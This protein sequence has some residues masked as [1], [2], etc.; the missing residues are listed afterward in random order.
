MAE[1]TCRTPLVDVV[2]T[3]RIAGPTPG[4]HASPRKI[5]GRLTQSVAGLVSLFI[6]ALSSINELTN[7]SFS[8]HWLTPLPLLTPSFFL[9]P[10]F[11]GF[12]R[13]GCR[14]ISGLSLFPSLQLGPRRRLGE[15]HRFR[16]PKVRPFPISA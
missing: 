3:N 12:S 11:R 2:S 14:K 15:E 5:T 6:A 8:S 10:Q 9:N 13:R 7:V 16:E 1:P 4:T